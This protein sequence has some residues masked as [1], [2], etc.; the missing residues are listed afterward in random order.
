MILRN[1]EGE[2]HLTKWQRFFDPNDTMEASQPGKL[3]HGLKLDTPLP[4][5]GMAGAERHI[6]YVNP[7]GGTRP[8][9][10]SGTGL[11]TWP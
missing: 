2:R 4:A 9:P 7:G 8:L 11:K 10:K 3:A 6:L 5:A 1:R